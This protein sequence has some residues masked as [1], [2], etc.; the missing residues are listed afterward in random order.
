[1]ANIDETKQAMYVRSIFRTLQ[2]TGLSSEVV[3][4]IATSCDVSDAEVK[5]FPAKN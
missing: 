1:M 4:A 2:M 5:S 3:D